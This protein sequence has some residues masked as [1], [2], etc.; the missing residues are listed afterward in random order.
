MKTL[1]LKIEGM[2]CAHCV[3]SLSE[4]LKKLQSLVIEEIKIGTARVRYDE[5]TITMG[6]LSRAV[7][8]AGYALVGD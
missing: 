8:Q 1:D 3:M 6:D 2:S 5:K 4:Q 7:E